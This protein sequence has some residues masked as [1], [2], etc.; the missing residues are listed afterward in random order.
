MATTTF[1]TT[2]SEEEIGEKVDKCLTDGLIK[3]G[4]GGALGAVFSILLF[5]R[6]GWPVAFG[7]GTGLGMAVSNCQH[8]FK[9]LLPTV[10]LGKGENVEVTEN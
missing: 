6:K 4:A 2:R 5:K 7:V 8:Q 3:A 1:H 10:S 9:Q